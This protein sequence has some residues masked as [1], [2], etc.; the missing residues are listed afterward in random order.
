[1]Q[2]KFTKENLQKALTVLQK[3]SQNR[4]NSNLPGTIYINANDGIVEM[5]ANDFEIGIKIIV[6]AEI[7][8]PGII[9]LAS[10]YFQDMIRHMAGEY[11]E[12][13]RPENTKTVIIRSGKAE[14]KL[15]T[16]D[17]NDFTLVDQIYD[18]Y[19]LNMDTQDLKTL[20]D[21]TIYSVSTDES[22][23]IFTGSLMEIHG[24]EVAMVGTDTH[25]LAVKKITLAEECP[26]VMESII[27][28]KVLSE[29]S[30]LLPIDNPQLV[31]I[32]WN[33]TQIAFVFEN[34][35]MIARLIEGKFPDYEKIIPTQF[36]A[37]AIIDRKSLIGAVERVSIVSKDI[38]Y[39]AIKFDWSEG[40]LLLS[41]QSVEVG[42]AKELIDC[43]FKGP[44][45]TISFNGRYISDILKHSTG[46]KVYFNLND[47]G[48]V[49]VR[50]DENPNYTYVATP[51]RT[52]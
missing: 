8:E 20:I 11:I 7:I 13:D 50:Q 38:S 18:D 12:L 26:F 21:L 51:I 30:R 29:L 19:H 15:M 14:F 32:I 22:R 45:L 49:V 40:K 41:S 17:A 46:D 35:Y 39:N 44:D 36:Y 3:A 5:Q 43:D 42:D 25:R 23:P 34:V 28:A 27:P 16:F 33:N 10:K 52:N 37:A 31:N 24:N 4:V 6:N 47:R 9:V 48:P 1:M 2:I